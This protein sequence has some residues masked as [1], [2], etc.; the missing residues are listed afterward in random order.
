MEKLNSWGQ[1]ASE[2]VKNVFRTFIEYLP[3]IIGAVLIFF[4]GWLFNKIISYLLKKVFKVIE[5]NI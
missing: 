5:V 2:T 3:N 1:M 4:L